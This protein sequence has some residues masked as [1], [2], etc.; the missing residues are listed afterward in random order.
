[1]YYRKR[2]QHKKSD[3]KVQ[4]QSQSQDSDPNLD[5]DESPMSKFENTS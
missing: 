3:D 1:M 4:I 5:D 2:L